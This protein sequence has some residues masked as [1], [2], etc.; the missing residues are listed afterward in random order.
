MTA[1]RSITYSNSSRVKS[2]NCRK[3]LIGVWTAMLCRE[4]G[5]LPNYILSIQGL[6]GLMQQLRI[7]FVS[8]PGDFSILD[9]A[10]HRALRLGQVAAVVVF[11]AA[12]VGLELDESP[13]QHPLS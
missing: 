1:A 4:C 2:E 7:E 6:F 5:D 11:A 9:R 8:D 13:L 3:C 12:Q 10:Q